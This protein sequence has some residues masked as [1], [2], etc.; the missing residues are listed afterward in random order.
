LAAKVG[1]KNYYDSKIKP[2]LDKIRHWLN[3]G[4]SHKQIC[5]MLS[6][7]Q[8]T[9]YKY[10]NKDDKTNYK[11]EF[12]DILR[13][14]KD[15]LEIKLVNALYKEAM[16]YEYTETHIEIEEDEVDSIKKTKK[17][18]KKITKYCRANGQLLIFALCNKFPNKWK[19]IDKDVVDAIEEGKLKLD[20]TDKH[21]ESAFKSLYPAISDSDSKKIT[22]EARKK[23]QDEEG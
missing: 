8:T 3:E 20:I 17:K 21:I 15:I 23:K 4:Y 18:Q 13:N 22:N 16:G 10:S 1:K 9:L 7:S 12:A 19:R 14:G 11:K 5:N 6:I 2:N